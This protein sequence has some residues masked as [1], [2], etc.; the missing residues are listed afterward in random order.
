MDLVRRHGAGVIQQSFTF[1]AIRRAT[2]PPMPSTV[3]QEIV[4]ELLELIFT[5]NFD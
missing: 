3:R 1:R 2:L 5:F 4:G